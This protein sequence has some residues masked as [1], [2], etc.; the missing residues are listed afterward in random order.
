M[1]IPTPNAVRLSVLGLAGAVPIANTFWFL[2][3][4]PAG[5]SELQSIVNTFDDV[6]RALFVPNLNQVYGL[7]GY[8][9][10]AQDSDSAPVFASPPAAPANG[11]LTGVKALPSQTALVLSFLTTDRSRSGRGRVFFGPLDAGSTIDE[12]HVTTQFADTL[13]ANLETMRASMAAISYQHVVVS[14]QHNKVKLSQGVCRGVSS[15]RVNRAIDTIR[16]RAQR[17]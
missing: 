14:H 15:Y 6:W 8:T 16:S 2:G 10:Y 5:L 17:D 12:N 1:F 3:G 13:R 7:I 9:A 11:G 4:A